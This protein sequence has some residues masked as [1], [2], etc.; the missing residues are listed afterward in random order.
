MIVSDLLKPERTIGHGF[1][2][3]LGGV[4]EGLYESLNCGLGSHDKKEK[5][6]ENRSR[7]TAKL[8][9]GLS[10][11]LTV[12]QIHSSRAVVANKVWAPDQA[13]EADA[14]VTATR[15]LAIGVL[16]ADCTPILFCDSEAGVIGAAH[17]G[18][19]GAKTGIIDGVIETM[20]KLGAAKERICAA[21]G[22]AISQKSYEV[23]PEFAASFLQADMNNRQFFLRLGTDDRPHFDLPG[24]CTQRL[25][26]AGVTQIDSLGLC[27]Y[28]N[29]SLFFSYRRSVHRGE[30]DYGRQISAIVLM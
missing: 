16:T 12:Y 1:F 4:S 6:H 18:W 23:G 7:V 3:R 20:E 26:D 14:I 2:T 29:E 17:A 9:N 27:T 15:G 8:G 19:R 22:P 24:Y 11:P 28:E 10:G 30:A 13:P 21:V 5:V 25:R